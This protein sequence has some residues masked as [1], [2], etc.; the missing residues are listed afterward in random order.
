MFAQQRGGPDDA[1]L[2]LQAFHSSEVSQKS[3]KWARFNYSRYVSKEFDA[4]HEIASREL[5]P[6][7]FVRGR[8][9]NEPSPP[10]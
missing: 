4:L 6:V 7:K 1:T 9:E 5:D 3:N 2:F 10:R 8:K